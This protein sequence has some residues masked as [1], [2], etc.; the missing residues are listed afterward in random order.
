MANKILETSLTD[1]ILKKKGNSGLSE[2]GQIL[3]LQNDGNW[4]REQ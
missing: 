3:K 4:F 2:A 1:L